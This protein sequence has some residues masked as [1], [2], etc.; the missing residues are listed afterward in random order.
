MH[1]IGVACIPIAFAFRFQSRPLTFPTFYF[2][3]II[4]VYSGVRLGM[5]RFA[6]KKENKDHEYQQLG[7]DR[8]DG[9]RDDRWDGMK[10]ERRFPTI[11]TPFISHYLLDSAS[12]SGEQE[13]CFRI[14][15]HELQ[16]L[17]PLPSSSAVID[18][19]TTT[20]QQLTPPNN[21]INLTLHHHSIPKINQNQAYKKFKTARQNH[22]FHRH[23]PF[24]QPRLKEQ[25]KHG[26]GPHI[27]H[28]KEKEGCLL[29][30]HR[31][32]KSVV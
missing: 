9:S 7:E 6:R 18:H 17:S 31:D 8:S 12:G 28:S 23:C 20:T 2:H 4:S 16:L 5:R 30:T 15:G 22:L 13:F 1:L 27:K 24:F 11:F 14:S 25:A 21:Y 26:A 29:L 19:H 3:V 10:W 32:R